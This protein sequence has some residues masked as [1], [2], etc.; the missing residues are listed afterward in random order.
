MMRMTQ[1]LSQIKFRAINYEIKKIKKERENQFTSHSN[2]SFIIF[3]FPTCSIH[4]QIV[5]EKTSPQ[6]SMII[7]VVCEC[8]H[9]NAEKKINLNL[10]EHFLLLFVNSNSRRNVECDFSHCSGIVE[11]EKQQHNKEEKKAFSFDMWT[12]EL[13]EEIELAVEPLSN[14]NI[15]EWIQISVTQLSTNI[16]TPHPEIHFACCSDQFSVLHCF[17]F[18]FNFQ[19]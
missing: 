3:K 18:H 8:E 12:R 9:V 14:R 19:D 10:S 2:K 5:G 15:H 6:I 11:M 4:T 16:L 7:C 13:I 1:K 17:F